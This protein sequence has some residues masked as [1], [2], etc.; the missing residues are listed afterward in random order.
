MVIEFYG[1]P[2]SGKTTVVKQ[3]CGALLGVYPQILTADDYLREYCSKMSTIKSFF[4]FSGLYVLASGIKTAFNH[5][6]LFNK[7]FMI[8]IVRILP[9]LDFYRKHKSDF[10]IMDQAIIQ[11]YVSAFYNFCEMNE[12]DCYFLSPLMKKY[13]IKT[14]H[15]V[16]PKE[17]AS[18]RI[19]LRA[20]K[21]HGRLD[22]I[23]N[24]S[25]RMN[26]LVIQERNFNVCKSFLEKTGSNFE[27][28][29]GGD[30]FIQIEPLLQFVRT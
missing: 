22:S 23:N 18:V 17:I 21:K 29:N 25:E 8:S 9:V 14:V 28:D 4:H 5:H 13:N 7:E 16:V 10:I 24:M 3:L 30:R 6:L 26:N 1:L 11:Q 27:V 12:V 19:S 2:G 20:D 15:V